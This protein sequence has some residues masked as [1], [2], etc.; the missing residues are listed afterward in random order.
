[1][2][3]LNR[4]VKEMIGERFVACFDGILGESERGI[5][6]RHGINFRDLIWRFS[7]MSG[8]KFSERI[9][10]YK[11]GEF[12]QLYRSDVLQLVSRYGHSKGM[13][14]GSCLRSRH[15][16]V[17]EYAEAITSFFHIAP[18]IRAGQDTHAELHVLRG[19]HPDFPASWQILSVVV[20]AE[21]KISNSL[22]PF[23]HPSG[24]VNVPEERFYWAAILYYIAWRE[25]GAKKQATLRAALS[26]LEGSLGTSDKES[27]VCL[28]Q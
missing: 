16:G 11:N 24:F 2:R 22:R 23:V 3:L 12:L 20:A 28:M 4:K 26:K 19:T 15:F 18:K 7:E 10:S 17:I 14:I 6:L 25:E 27:S 9:M 1:M 21:K 13:G 5:D 8:V